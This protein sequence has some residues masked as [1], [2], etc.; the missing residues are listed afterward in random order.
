MSPLTHVATSAL[1]SLRAHPL[2]T[3]LSMLGIVMGAALLAAV[4]ALGDG[5][6]QF[7]REQVE[8]EGMNLVLAQPITEDVIDGLRVPRPSFPLFTAE[9]AARV[10]A[11]IGPVASVLLQMEGT[12]LVQQLG[13]R[14]RAARVR[15]VL[16]TGGP[17]PLPPLADGRTLSA[18][19]MKNGEPVAIVSAR[20]YEL[21]APQA[22]GGVA[23]TVTL[24]STPHTIVGRLAPFAGERE[25]LVVVPYGDADR[26]MVPAQGPRAR[27]LVL[28]SQRVEDVPA[29][30]RG[31]EDLAARRDDWRGAVRIEATG[32]ARLQQVAKGI[33]VF[34]MLMG[35]FSA[36]S[37]LVGGIGITNVLLASMLE[38][39]REIGIRKAVGARQRDVLLQFLVESVSITTVGALAGAALGMVGAVAVTAIIRSTTEVPIFAAMTWQTAAVS[40]GAAVI[41]GLLAGTYPALRAAR[42]TPVEAIQR[43]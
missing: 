3:S 23:R 7:A 20:L 42:L 35:A 10:S 21:L 2:R 22:E 18:D 1:D 39:T 37:L 14:A 12:G 13:K 15:A 8:R 16:A 43:E 40:A 41:V 28:R 34:K 31:L 38:R 27:S 32:A 6:Q 19:E 26:A 5:A 29:A 36:I 30:K 25:F 17:P 9:D 11:A 33:L 24:G 4:L